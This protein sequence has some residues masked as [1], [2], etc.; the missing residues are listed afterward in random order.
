[1]NQKEIAEIKR[2]FHPDKSN[3]TDIC[4]CYVNEKK[5]IVSEFNQSM[6]SME[7]D[8]KA[9]V[10]T[11]LKKTLSG[12]QGKN[13]IDIDFAT[14]Q[15][16]DSD[17]HRMLMALRKSGLKDEE[18]VKAFYSRVIDGLSIEGNYL[19]LL[20]YDKYDIAYKSKD[21]YKNDDSSEQVFSY[22]MC[23]ICPIKE[24]K[25]ALKFS[26]TDGTFHNFKSVGMV[27]PP[28]LGFV[29]PAFDD[30]NANIYG[31]LYYTKDILEGHTDFIKAIF[32]CEVPMSA[33]VQKETFSQLLESTLE[34]ECSY[35]VVQS[36]HNS[37]CEIITEHKVNKVDEPLVISKK[38]MQNVLKSCGIEDDRVTEFEEKYDEEFGSNTK[39]SPSNIVDAKQFKLKTADVS[40]QV[41]P[42]RN[43]LVETRI[44]DGRKYIMILVEEG[45]ELNGVNVQ[46]GELDTQM[47]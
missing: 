37:L 3:I 13:L 15:V 40:I 16:V 4:G 38:T 20:A 21:G 28:A 5:E 35:E 18:M 9:E 46:I 41:N 7:E 6:F 42:Q 2:R 12:T 30:R 19:I 17:E 10:L 27:A 29:F 43:N 31:A 11:V 47:N 34:E 39:L 36:V 25:P 22:I 44:I 14:A 1:M 24:I 33:T 8:E 32:N 26:I 23:S 45:V